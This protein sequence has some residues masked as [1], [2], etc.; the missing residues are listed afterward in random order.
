[1]DSPLLDIHQRKG[2]EGQTRRRFAEQERKEAVSAMAL[3]TSLGHHLI[4]G[5]DVAAHGADGS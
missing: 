1:M 2:E 4:L 3:V 5:Q